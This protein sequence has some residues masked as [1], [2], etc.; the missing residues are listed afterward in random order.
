[1]CHESLACD[2][3]LVDWFEKGTG[4]MPESVNKI[5]DIIKMYQGDTPVGEAVTA[6][7][8]EEFSIIRADCLCNCKDVQK[9]L[10]VKIPLLYQ[11]CKNIRERLSKK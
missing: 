4:K 7:Y 11:E 10:Q 2:Q 6:L 9:K 1:M 5:H 3:A 8:Y